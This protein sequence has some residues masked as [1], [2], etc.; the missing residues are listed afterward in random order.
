MKGG[1]MKGLRYISQIFGMT[2]WKILCFYHSIGKNSNLDFKNHAKEVKE[3][4]AQEDAGG[5]QIGFPT[6]VKH[7]AHIGMDGPTVTPPTWVKK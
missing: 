7:V 3:E 2:I 1:L 5:M 4:D 6:D